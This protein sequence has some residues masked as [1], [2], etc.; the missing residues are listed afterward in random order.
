MVWAGLAWEQAC[1]KMVIIC[2][3]RC[4]WKN[5]FPKFL[6][7]SVKLRASGFLD[8][9]IG[10]LL[11]VESK[12]REIKE[13]YAGLRSGVNSRLGSLSQQRRTLST[14][15]ASLEPFRAIGS[16]SSEDKVCTALKEA[17]TPDSLVHTPSSPSPSPAWI[18]GLNESIMVKYF[19][20]MTLHISVS[21]RPSLISSSC[22]ERECFIH[23]F[24]SLGER[25]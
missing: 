11:P 3:S 7:C 22:R 20:L 18:T 21:A 1:P 13:R 12:L 17:L 6:S 23:P 9:V 16:S 2:P 10:R 8:Y 24:L 4:C 25:R 15:A 19:P 5:F 14:A